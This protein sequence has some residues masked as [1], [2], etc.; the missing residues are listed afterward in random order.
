MA[1]IDI[2]SAAINRAITATI[3]WTR[4]V[5]DN[6]AN[7]TGT[8]D[9]VEIW[10]GTNGSDVEVATFI[11]EG[12]N[13]FSTRDS[14]IIG[15]VTSGSKQ[16]FSGLAMDVT[17]GDYLGIYGSAGSI[18]YDFS[19]Y[20][21]I[22]TKEGDFIPCTSETFG[23]GTAETISLYG[24]GGI[25][26]D[27][28]AVGG[29]SVATAGVLASVWARVLSVGSGSIAIAGTLSR[30]SQFYRNMGAASMTI[31]GALIKQGYKTVGAASMTIAGALVRMTQKVMGSA[32]MTIV[33]V[34]STAIVLGKA[35]G[36][37]SI[38]VAGTLSTVWIKVLSVGSGSIA[39]SG[40]LSTVFTKILA[41]GGA[42]MSIVGTLV[43]M[44][45]K[46]MGSASMTIVG[47]LNFNMSRILSIFSSIFSNDLKIKSTLSTDLTIESTL[48]D[49]LTIKS[50][51]KGG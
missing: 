6:P 21:G 41:V 28:Q 27:L 30:F 40:V 50:T 24:T 8:I 47:A 29:G 12:S 13:V 46:T 1:V 16:T 51:L 23:A 31:A 3:I 20:N 26:G 9:T 39:I 5:T 25:A 44:T 38:A 17:S 43:K 45:Q 11:H 19:G 35:V 42:S 15:A 32:S 36:A 18:E 37:G 14:E 48:S 49:D 22:W 7:G 2:G 33:G 10:L 4:V 34:L